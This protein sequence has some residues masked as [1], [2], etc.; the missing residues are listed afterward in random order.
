MRKHVV[1]LVLAMGIASCSLL[2][3]PGNELTSG[4]GVAP[5]AEGGLVDG[6]VDT[7]GAPAGDAPS[8][9]ATLPAIPSEGLVLWLRGDDG[10]VM[11]GNRVAAW[12]DATPA[13]RPGAK[14]LNAMQA[15]G[16][17]R[18]A[19]GTA[20]NG[21]STVVFE[22][23]HTLEL[24]FGFADF[25]KGLSVFVAFAF[26]GAGHGGPALALGIGGNGCA[27]SA[28]LFIDGTG[29]D[30]RVENT[31]VGQSTTL[32]SG[33]QVISAVAG[34][35]DAK[36]DV[37]GCDRGRVELRR[38]DVLLGEGV[39]KVPNVIGRDGSRLGRSNLYS[40]QYLTSAVGEIVLYDRALS[41]AETTAV[42]AYLDRKWA[43]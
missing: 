38:S 26:P 3:G 5:P 16:D 15:N 43:R 35:H 7:D 22:G 36:Y 20:P 10:I 19:R 4:E 40:D 27:R 34:P 21:L 33:W 37:D 24:P 32:S 8:E 23:R 29:V 31:D 25:T 14:P 30:Y 6:E 39:V 11:G 1:A 2:Y 42:S 12:N 9:G 18:P 41:A 13:L 17:L 28:E